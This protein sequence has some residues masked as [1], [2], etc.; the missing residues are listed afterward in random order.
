MFEKKDFNTIESEHEETLII[1]VDNL[2]E[3]ALQEQFSPEKLTEKDIESIILNVNQ[4]DSF[5]HEELNSLNNKLKDYR[6]NDSYENTFYQSYLDFIDS[7]RKNY[8]KSI[9]SIK[10]NWNEL[11]EEVLNDT[12]ND[13]ENINEKYIY[14]EKNIH[15]Y[16]LNSLQLYL[17]EY[18]KK[19][20][21]A[22]SNYFMITTNNTYNQAMS[23]AFSYLKYRD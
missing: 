12:S 3:N 4:Q 16:Y 5:S 7:F 21:Y 18:K 20:L 15:K 11:K 2:F 8:F 13:F 6:Y 19:L 14:L 17:E 10:N 1:N 9:E 23:E 22:S